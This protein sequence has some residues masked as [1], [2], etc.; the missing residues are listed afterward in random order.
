MWALGQTGFEVSPEAGAGVGVLANT[1]TLLPD[2]AVLHASRRLC[3]RV[4]FSP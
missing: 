2:L 4:V 3:K 1:R